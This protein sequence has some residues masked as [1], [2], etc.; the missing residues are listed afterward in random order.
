MDLGFVVNLFFCVNVNRVVVCMC[1]CSLELCD[2]FC[3]FSSVLDF[4]NI[5]CL[6][7][8]TLTGFH[9]FTDLDVVMHPLK[10]QITELV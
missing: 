6:V 10:Y 5:G 9:L 3:K 2:L 4:V 8:N 7:A 1:V